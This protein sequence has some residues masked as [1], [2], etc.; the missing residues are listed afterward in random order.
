MS[1]AQHQQHDRR[2]RILQL[3]SKSSGYKANESLIVS[4]LHF[5]GHDDSGDLVRT[6]LA[7][8]E[9]QGLISIENV[10]GLS[11]CA[12]NARGIDVSQGRAA[13]PGIRKPGPEDVR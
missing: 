5:Y 8:L 9:E 6:E 1:F 13:V 2:L 4:G 10:A 12:I 3:L 7:W 11:I